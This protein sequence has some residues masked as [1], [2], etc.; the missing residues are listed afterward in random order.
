[1]SN[2]LLLEVGMTEL[3]TLEGDIRSTTVLYL[4][5]VLTIIS[6]I[7][8]T[9]RTNSPWLQSQSATSAMSKT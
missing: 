5:S 3:E 6:S 4:T 9:S 7:S 1:M 2:R 8:S